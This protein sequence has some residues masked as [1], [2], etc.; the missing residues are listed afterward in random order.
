[1]VQDVKAAFIT[2]LDGLSVTHNSGTVTL[3]AA[4]WSDFYNGANT[5]PAVFIRELTSNV[6]T[7][8][9]GG[10]ELFDGTYDLAICAVRSNA[11][12]GEAAIA[13]AELFLKDAAGAINTTIRSNWSN[14]GGAW[15]VR[16]IH[17][18]DLTFENA[19]GT[20]IYTRVLT[21]R[22]HSA[23]TY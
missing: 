4:H 21:F 14:V 19:D 20:L 2:L 1:M 12:S 5:L 15:G 7:T 16:L 9:G 3:Q 10:T 13:D 6:E 17:T 22:A 8:I 23:E 11:K 18:R